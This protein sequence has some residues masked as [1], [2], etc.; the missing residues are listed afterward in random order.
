MDQHSID[1]GISDIPA[2][3]TG[4][5]W[6]PATNIATRYAIDDDSQAYND[7]TF[8]QTSTLLIT[9]YQLQV[10]W[11]YK[12]FDL[13]AQSANFHSNLHC[14]HVDRFFI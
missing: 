1:C 2:A 11:D 10:G 14:K 4:V 3:Y 13:K 9:A 8:T 5:T 6:R 7:Q 12:S